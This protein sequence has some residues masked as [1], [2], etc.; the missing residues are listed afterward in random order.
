MSF[1]VKVLAV[2]FGLFALTVVALLFVLGSV[3]QLA[4]LAKQG[5]GAQTSTAASA[6]SSAHSMALISAG[7]FALALIAS[8]WWILTSWSQTIRQI[9]LMTESIDAGGDVKPADAM[10]SGELSAVS[11]KLNAMQSA[12]HRAN[13][14]TRAIASGDLDVQHRKSAGQDELVDSIDSMLERL[15]DVIGKVSSN[16]EQVAVGAGQMKLTS[17]ALSDGAQRQAGAAQEA[18]AA[19][20]EMTENIKQSAENASQTERIANQAAG[21]AKHSGEAVG[22]AVKAMKTI[23]DKI[24]I[25]QEIARQTDL[26]ALNAAVEAARAGE[27]GKGFAV[28][29]AEVRKL[30]E[31]SQHAAQEIG[32]LSAETVGVSIEAGRML[33]QLVPNIQ[34][35]ADLVQQISAATR[36]QDIGASQINEAISDLDRVIHQ[37]ASSAETAAATSDELA[38]RSTELKTTIGFFRTGS[39]ASSG[40]T[41]PTRPAVTSGRKIPTAEGSTQVAPKQ[42]PKPNPVEQ[43][44]PAEISAAPTEPKQDAKP[45][46]GGFDLDLDMGVSDDDFQAYQ[47]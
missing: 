37:N 41:A 34:Q 22:K 3:D 9:D 25:V 17:D 1:K 32:E 4:E 19:V 42:V 24:T 40:F 11:E 35:T 28:V 21:E 20:A 26:L 31:R 14:V 23:A 27:H 12:L 15:R 2:C 43:P 30:A 5:S 36:E 16:A 46:L 47:G 38:A 8:G 7:M 6:L 39:N 45:D 44:K 29:A 10:I 33:E 18:A 13:A